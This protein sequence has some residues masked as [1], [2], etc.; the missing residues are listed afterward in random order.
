MYNDYHSDGTL[1]TY[2]A[3]KITAQDLTNGYL[4]LAENV[5]Y[6]I[7]ALP[8]NTGFGY[9]RSFFDIKYQLML[10]DITNMY[11]YIGDLAYY[12]QIQQYL[13]TLDNVLNG[14]PQVQ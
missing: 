6:V 3:Y 2:I 9:T 11:S 14:Q 12:E 4:P 5:N 7:R 8:I 13:T 10:N 1:R